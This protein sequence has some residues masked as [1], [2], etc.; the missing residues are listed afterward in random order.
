MSMHRCHLSPQKDSPTIPLTD[1]SPSV[2]EVKTTYY[3]LAKRHTASL[4]RR[5][6]RQSTTDS[7]VV[8]ACREMGPAQHAYISS[9]AIP[10]T[11][12]ATGAINCIAQCRIISF[13]QQ[14]R[15]LPATRWYKV[16]CCSV[17]THGNPLLPYHNLCFLPAE[18]RGDALLT[19]TREGT[20]A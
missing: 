13:A 20:P 14:R 16:R 17:T 7:R 9:S 10:D 4:A 15:I 2:S 18:K 5:K 8:T 6:W 11:E 1:A 12:A 19:L 3:R